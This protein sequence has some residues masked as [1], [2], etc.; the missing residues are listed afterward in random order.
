[1][2]E[3]HM[4]HCV[5]WNYLK[6][7]S[8][9]ANKLL[10]YSV[11]AALLATRNWT[12][13][14]V[15]KCDTQKEKEESQARETVESTRVYP[16]YRSVAPSATDSCST[17]KTEGGER[18]GREGVPHCGYESKWGRQEQRRITAVAYR[19]VTLFTD[20]TTALRNRRTLM[21]AE[22]ERRRAKRKQQYFHE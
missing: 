5:N 14:I 16:L 19:A 8:L 2:N 4:Q 10:N 18:E 12:R 9:R 15:K 3:V 1:M 7:K 6:P 22:R 17:A 11:C 13:A 21:G 20:E